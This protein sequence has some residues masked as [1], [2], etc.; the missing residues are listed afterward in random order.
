MV[1]LALAWGGSDYAWGS[2]TILGLF[3]G[4]LVFLMTFVAWER[5]VG[6]AAMIPPSVVCKL[7]VWSSSLYL[8]FLSAGM[9]ICSYYLPIYFQAVKGVSALF[10]GVYMLPGVLPQI[11]MAVTSGALSKSGP[12]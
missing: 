10:S 5:R 1:E 4:S 3:F 6:D 2:V 8:G 11:A 9:L 12:T 7:E